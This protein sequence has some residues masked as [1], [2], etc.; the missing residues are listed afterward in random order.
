MASAQLEEDERQHPLKPR[1]EP[2]AASSGLCVLDN[3]TVETKAWDN[4]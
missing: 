2:V 1:L 4:L 3:D